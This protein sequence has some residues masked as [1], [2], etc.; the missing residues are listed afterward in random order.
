MNTEQLSIGQRINVRMP[1]FSIETPAT[2]KAKVGQIVVVRCG[3]L[4]DFLEDGEATRMLEDQEIAY[5]PKLREEIEADSEYYL[6]FNQHHIN[7]RRVVVKEPPESDLYFKQAFR[8]TLYSLLTPRHK[9]LDPELFD[10][11]KLKPEV[12]EKILGTIES[13][14]KRNNINSNLVTGVYLIGSSATH[15]WDQ[16]SDIDVTIVTEN[17]S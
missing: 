1:Q 8:N 17:F 10:G 15:H 16:E 7:I 12:R 2:V 5:D 14:L 4:V 6:L 11:D 3:I 9:T 13:E